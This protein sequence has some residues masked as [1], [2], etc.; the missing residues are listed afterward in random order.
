MLLLA[1]ATTSRYP[2]GPHQRAPATHRTVL[3]ASLLLQQAYPA[4]KYRRNYSSITATA[5]TTTAALLP[6]LC[7]LL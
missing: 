7:S 5:T 2:Q 4:L 6:V 1:A 3:Q